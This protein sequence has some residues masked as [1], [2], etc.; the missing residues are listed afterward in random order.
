MKFRLDKSTGMGKNS[1]HFTY[2]LTMGF[3]LTL[4]M[5]EQGIGL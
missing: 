1:N 5:Q 2:K 4:I 3:E